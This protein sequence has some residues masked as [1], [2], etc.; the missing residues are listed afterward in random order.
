MTPTENEWLATLE[1]QSIQY[2]HDIKGLKQSIEKINGRSN[3]ILG[4][5]L[6]GLV[7]IGADIV[8]RMTTGG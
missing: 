4:A 3:Q 6:V 7:M 1:A 5:M 8:V 2:Y